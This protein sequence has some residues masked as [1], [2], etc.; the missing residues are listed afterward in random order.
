[1]TKEQVQAVQFTVGT[2][3]W[4]FIKKE[5]LSM[6]DQAKLQL[7]LTEDEREVVERW[8]EARAA[9]KLLQMFLNRVENPDRDWS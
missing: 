2:Q 6:A 8:R 9:H 3:G 5:L 4:Q 1:M 7:M